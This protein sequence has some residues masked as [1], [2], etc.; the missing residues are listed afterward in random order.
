MIPSY[1]IIISGIML[2]LAITAVC[3]TPFNKENEVFYFIITLILAITIS[4]SCAHNHTITKKVE[5][6]L[7]FSY[8]T[9]EPYIDKYN[10]TLSYLQ[11]KIIDDEIVPYD[12]EIMQLRKIK[13]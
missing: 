5:Y 4:G 6:V 1:L 7:N 3:L 8:P 11:N 10:E 9:E 2:I 12:D 13:E